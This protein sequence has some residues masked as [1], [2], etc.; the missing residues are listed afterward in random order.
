MR[1]ARQAEIAF[2]RVIEDKALHLA[3]LWHKRDALF[4]RLR[5]PTKT[6]NLTAN[7]ELAAR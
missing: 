3:I 6:P 2:N 4:D 7:P 1:K 5:R